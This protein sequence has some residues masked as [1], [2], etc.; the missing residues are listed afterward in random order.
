MVINLLLP[1]VFGEANHI[2]SLE[3]RALRGDSEVSARSQMAGSSSARSLDNGC[4][5]VLY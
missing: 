3:S 2:F 1:A 5:F 4:G